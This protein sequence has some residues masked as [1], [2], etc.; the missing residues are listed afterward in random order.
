MHFVP[1]LWRFHR[2]HHSDRQV[3]ALTTLL[4]HP[5]EVIINSVLIVGFYVAFD[6]P[7]ILIIFYN[8]LLAFHSAFVHS[9]ITIPKGMEKWFGYIFVMPVMH[10]SHH[11]IDVTYGD[12]N[13]GSIF[14]IWDRLLG[15][16]KQKEDSKTN[17][18]VFGVDISKTP[19]ENSMQSFLINPLV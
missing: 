19:K 9:T 7:I 17:S 1:F 11:S 14:S 18:T 8:I 4:H 15:T 2:L 13:F 5:L 3:D 12:A 16:Y 10:R 6:L